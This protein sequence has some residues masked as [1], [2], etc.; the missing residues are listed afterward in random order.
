MMMS[1][2]GK[3]YEKGKGFW[4]AGIACRL[5]A[6]WFCASREWSLPPQCTTAPLSSPLA[7]ANESA[8]AHACG[9]TKW[10]RAPS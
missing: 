9:Q 4:R 5:S 10:R 1:A 2:N 8:R 7:A 3:K 6:L